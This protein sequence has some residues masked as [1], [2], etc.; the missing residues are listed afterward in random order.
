MS[1]NVIMYIMIVFTLFYCRL[2]WVIL[3]IR[4]DT[5]KIKEDVVNMWFYQTKKERKEQEKQNDSFD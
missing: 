4:D 1:D 2:L 5:K 3:D